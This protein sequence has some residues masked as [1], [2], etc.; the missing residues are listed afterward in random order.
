M[1]RILTE[2]K[3]KTEIENILIALGL[4][5]TI[6]EAQGTWKG[7]RENPWLLN[8]QMLSLVKL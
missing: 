5:F 2:N 6:L 4:D 1:L 8:S 7:I 3:Q